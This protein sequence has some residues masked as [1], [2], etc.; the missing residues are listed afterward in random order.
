MQ[1]I[2]F[3]PFAVKDIFRALTMDSSNSA[4]ITLSISVRY[5]LAIVSLFLP[6]TL[7]FIPHKEVRFIYP[8]LPMIHILAAS[9]FKGFYVPIISN[10]GRAKKHEIQLRS[11]TLSLLFAAHICIAL[12]TT[13][14]HQPAPLSVLTYLR[15]EYATRSKNSTQTSLRFHMTDVSNLMTVGFLMPCHSTPWRSHLVFPGIKAWALGCEPPVQLNASARAT[16]V[17][18]ADRFYANPSEFLMSTLGQPPLRNSSQLRPFSR[19]RNDLGSNQVWAWD[20]QPGKK[21][22]PEY[23]IFF[24]TLQP[25]LTPILLG[26]NYSE[27]WRGWNSYFHDDSRR[28]GDMVV[29]CS[30]IDAAQEQR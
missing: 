8:I 22:W 5:Q 7:S 9:S 10:T 11:L 29:W 20:G 16:Y 26:T 28:K 24:E 19:K 6:I 23:L 27:C 25:S 18:E 14:Y 3:L 4:M 12:F 13:Q 30:G 1:L 17:D 21:L 15:N 2:F